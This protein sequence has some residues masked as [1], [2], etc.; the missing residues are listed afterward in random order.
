[1]TMIAGKVDL[2]V[3]ALAFYSLTTFCG[4]IHNFC[5][6]E[7][8]RFDAFEIVKVFFHSELQGI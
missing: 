4:N 7:L 5:L 2:E 6:W 1:M 8:K 3:V